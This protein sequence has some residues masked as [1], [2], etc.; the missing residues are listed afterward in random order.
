MTASTA[1]ATRA[2]LGSF[3]VWAAGVC[4]LYAFGSF[5]GTYW[6]QLAAGT[7]VKGTSLLHLHAA[8]FSGWCVLLLSQS[9]LVADGKVR[10]HRAWGVAGVSLATAMVVVGMATAIAAVN[11]LFAQ[12]YGDQAR[13]FFWLPVSGMAFFAVLFT[14]AVLN[15]NDREWHKRLMFGATAAILPAA[16]AR[17]G[18]LL[19]TGGGPGVRPG[20]SPPPPPESGMIG[21]LMVAPLLL[22]GIVYDW[23]T[24]GRPHPAWFVGLAALLLQGFGGA[25]FAHTHAWYA[26]VDAMARFAG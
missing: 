5:A 1:A 6:L 8:L 18:F 7:F 23:R 10:D 12:G 14:A 11:R 3:Y 22:A 26:F 16:S 21:A 17:I 13:A 25:W 2:R 4:A 19:A 9:W 20:L 24:R 15:A